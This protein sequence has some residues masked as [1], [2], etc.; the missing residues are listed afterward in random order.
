MCW[1]V[2]ENVHSENPQWFPEVY[3]DLR[4][5]E[6]KSVLYQLYSLPSYHIA[7]V[8]SQT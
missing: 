5:A 3:V 4:G 6:N 7:S 8:H 2:E 1:L